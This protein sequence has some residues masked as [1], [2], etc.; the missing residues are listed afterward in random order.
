MLCLGMHHDAEATTFL[1]VA[2][3]PEG[4]SDASALLG[5]VRMVRW[6]AD[7]GALGCAQEQ[8][9]V[10]D[11]GTGTTAIGASQLLSFKSCMASI[12]ANARCFSKNTSVIGTANEEA[13][14]FLF[15]Q[16]WPSALR[17]WV[18]HGMSW[19]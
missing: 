11:S 16:A 13:F 4:A 1:Q 19:V 12:P 8:T 2:V 18:C 6:L 3:I 15:V 7:S 9:I 10:V 5:L 17:C 14:E